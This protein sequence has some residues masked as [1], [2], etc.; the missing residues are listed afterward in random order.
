MANDLSN[1]SELEPAG[2]DLISAGD[3][4]IRKT[5][6]HLKNWAGI[7]HYLTGEHKFQVTGTPPTAGNSGRIYVD[8]ALD[9]VMR[10]TG[11]AWTKV[12]GNKTIV[13]LNSGTMSLSSGVWTSLTS[14]SLDVASGASI[15]L[16]F[17][18]SQLVSDLQGSTELRIQIGGATEASYTWTITTSQASISAS[19]T[20]TIFAYKSSPTGTNLIDLQA[21]LFNVTTSTATNSRLV[22]IV[23]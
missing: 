18:E 9:A 1:L 7:E 14:Q 2:T 16:A 6:E 3:D 23:L 11:S 20:R 12:I 13:S 17:G 21:R 4:E 19:L 10:D 15:I 22:A 8:T 5:R